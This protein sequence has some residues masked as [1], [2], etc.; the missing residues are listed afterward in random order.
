MLRFIRFLR[1]INGRTVRKVTMCVIR[2]RLNGLSAEIA[3]NAMLGL[4]PAIITVLTAISR[5]ENS[6]E[7]TLG[8]LAIRFADII[9]SQVWDLL[10]DFTEQTRVDQGGN[11]FSLS[12]IAAIWIISGAIGSTMNAIDSINQIPRHQRRPYWK[13]KIIAILLTFGTITLLI[14]AC[15]LLI[16][17]DF[18][19]RLALQQNWDQLL[20]VIWQIFSIITIAAIVA[21]TISIV[22]Q[23]QQYRRQKSR[24]Q[25][26]NI[27]ITITIGVGIICVQ[28][29]YSVF[30]FVQ[31]LIVNFSVEEKVSSFLVSIWRLISFPVAFGIIALAFAS[32]YHFGCSK[33]SSRI[34][35]MPGAILSA[36]SWAVVSSVFRYYV[37][38]FGVYNKIYGALGTVVVLLLWLYLSALV[39]LI[40][41]QAN[42]TIG[43]TILAKKRKSLYLSG[44]CL[45]TNSTINN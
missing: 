17:G 26:K 10:L 35:L 20:L 42:L 12:L 14:A 32:I 39:M 43:R 24:S 41:E 3:F 5:F 15:F 2:R 18:L 33:R 37:G 30:V 8:S 4:F 36:I 6:V 44:K 25:E 7:E 34:P 28:L 31:S 1:H 45:T 22:Y 23:I 13:N 21:T 38:N 16:V 11:W 19:L 27:V 29:V 40:G 9:P